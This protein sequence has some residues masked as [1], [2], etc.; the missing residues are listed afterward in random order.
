M[1]GGGRRLGGIASPVV[2]VQGVHYGSRLPTSPHSFPEAKCPKAYQSEPPTR[3]YKVR[4]PCPNV[5]PVRTFPSMFVPSSLQTSC[6]SKTSASLRPVRDLFVAT[7]GTSVRIESCSATHSCRAGRTTV[8][9][10]FRTPP[11]LFL[12]PVVVVSLFRRCAR[13]LL[14]G[15]V[16][17]PFALSSWRYSQ[18][19]P[20]PLCP[21][22]E[23]L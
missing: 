5:T 20:S 18:S 4:L 21:Q 8:R 14:R 3:T 7:C 11:S 9:Q 12:F 22:V 19:S 17:V 16:R 1:G 6:P 10:S 15:C 2:F 23:T 13:A